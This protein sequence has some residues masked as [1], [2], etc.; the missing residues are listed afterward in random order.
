MIVHV[1]ACLCARECACL[2]V[3]NMC[4]PCMHELHCNIMH[5]L[6]AS[7]LVC[8]VCIESNHEPCVYVSRGL[9]RRQS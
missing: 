4:V 3:C 5:Y 7:K 2:C 8:I 9:A 1:F 6:Y